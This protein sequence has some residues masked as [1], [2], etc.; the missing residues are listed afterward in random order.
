MTALEKLR[1]AGELLEKYGIDDAEREAEIIISHCLGIDR[2]YLH[3]DNPEI[4]G[5]ILIKMDE[6]LKRRADR[7]PLQ[8][9]IGYTEFYGLKI[10]VGPGVLV[11]R[12]ETELLVEEAIKIVSRQTLNPPLPP[13]TKEGEE[14]ITQSQI[15]LTCS[16]R[17][18][19]LC[20]G[21][22]CI[23]LALA[24][25]FPG[26]EVFGTDISGTAIK[27]A[28]ENARLNDI[29]NTI[30]LEG[31]LFDPVKK[32]FAVRGKRFAAA[33]IIANPP[34]IKTDDIR[35][36]QPEIKDWEPTQA[37]DGGQDGLDY[38]RQIIPEAGNYLEQGGILMFELGINQADAIKKMA[39]NA[40]FQD[41]SI[42][43]DFAGIERIFF[44]RIRE[45]T[46]APLSRGD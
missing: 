11:P 24:S 36:L 17:I 12:P 18:L 37:L 21:T 27:Y 43:K 9:I 35:N 20:T 29:V 2:L 42:V 39:E 28:Q 32:L 30:F 31:T 7:E 38:Y 23:A 13:F 44:A 15:N 46:P 33:L 1:N 5:D 14:G 19:D 16:L 10:M 26:A 45:H 8:Y 4:P 34:Y 41:V 3:R 6:F 22:G 40:G 25:E